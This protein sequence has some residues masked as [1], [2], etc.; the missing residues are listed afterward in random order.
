MHT[1]CTSADREMIL[2]V[3]ERELG[4]RARVSPAPE[5][6]TTVGGVTLRR[7][8]RITAGE[9]ARLALEWLSELGLCDYP[10]PAELPGD[11]SVAWPMEQ[12]TGTSL[13]NLFCMLSAR[14]RL[15]NAALAARGAFRVEPG[16]MA[17]LLAHPPGAREELL[18]MLYGREAE[19][20]GLTLRRGWVIF[21]GFGRCP[22]GE[23][24]IHRQLAG[25]MVAVALR[26]RR[27]KAF[28]PNARNRKYA[29]R[30]WLNAIGM[31]GPEDEAARRTMLSRVRGRSD[32]RSLGRRREG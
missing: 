18:R 23:R 12:H 17:D 29:L 27:V 25:R 11:G 31:I 30:T 3:L 19:Y 1:Y 26:R 21:D 24:A 10:C 13:L 15:I 8:G 5:F 7:D 6:M 16:L 2:R 22:A 9:E 14:Q 4:A 20:A 28:T 32:Q